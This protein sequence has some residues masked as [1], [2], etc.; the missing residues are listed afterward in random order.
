M[1]KEMYEEL[2][3]NVC[4]M[5]FA[6]GQIFAQ[7]HRRRSLESMMNAFEKGRKAKEVLAE[8]LE[9]GGADCMKLVQAGMNPGDLQELCLEFDIEFTHEELV[10]AWAW[11]DD[12]ML[13][14]LISAPSF[15]E[16]TQE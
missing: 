10:A 3:F 8:S 13:E 4:E 7:R 12:K 14:S 15:P 6:I 2:G 11:Y 1:L 16:G 9:T 5:E